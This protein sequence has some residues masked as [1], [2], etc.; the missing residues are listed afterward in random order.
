LIKLFKPPKATSGELRKFGFI[1]AGALLLLGVV[2]PL[3]RH[4]PIKAW[5]WVVACVFFFAGLIYP[6]SLTKFHRLWMTL[7]HYLGFVN[8]RIILSVVFFLV[9]TPV[10]FALKALGKDPLNRRFSKDAATYREE[11][12]T[13]S[14]MDKPY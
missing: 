11:K 7:G 9:I 1:M 5:P 12:K 14:P 10:A 2:V 4:H 13:L 6:R 8:T 3:M